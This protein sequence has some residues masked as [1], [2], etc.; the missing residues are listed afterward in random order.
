MVSKR[1]DI[2]LLYTRLICAMRNPGV[3]KYTL[4]LLST[5]RFILQSP[6]SLRLQVLKAEYTP[7]SFN[8]QDHLAV[9]NSPSLPN[10]ASLYP[11]Q[12]YHSVL[13]WL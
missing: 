7:L 12:A 8:I 1:H 4:G 6:P 11:L 3:F 9:Q 5:V 10:H 13:L 2:D